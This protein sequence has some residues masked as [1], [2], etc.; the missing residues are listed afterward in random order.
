M[1]IQ[2]EA[3]HPNEKQEPETISG[4]PEKN[5]LVLHLSL[6]LGGLRQ[7]ATTVP[8]NS[9]HTDSHQRNAGRERYLGQLADRR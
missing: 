7:L 1:K 5:F 2:S 8:E 9:T 3:P 6:P 4:S